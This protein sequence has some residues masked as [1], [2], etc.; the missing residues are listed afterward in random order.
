MLHSDEAEMSIALENAITDVQ[1]AAD[2]NGLSIVL[3]AHP[4]DI[5]QVRGDLYLFAMNFRPENI[6]LNDGE[7]AGCRNLA[8]LANLLAAHLIAPKVARKSWSTVPDA[9]QQK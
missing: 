3:C 9:P 8:L 4:E 6:W 7:E 5:D 2:S 1:N